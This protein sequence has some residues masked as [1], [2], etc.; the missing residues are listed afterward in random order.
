MKIISILTGS[1]LENTYIVYDESSKKAMVIDP[2]ADAWK[3][4]NKIDELNLK[5]EYIL[6]THGH[7]DHI[8]A[9]DAIKDKYGAKIAVHEADARMLTSAR[10]NLS[11]FIGEPFNAYGAD[12]LLKDGD[13][14]ETDGLRLKVLH[15]PGHSQGSVC[16]IAEDVIFSGDTLFAGSV[17][18]TD[19]PD[20]SPE[21]MRESLERLK[22]LKGDYVVYPGHDEQTTLAEEKLTNPYLGR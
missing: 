6:L 20:S 17:G 22:G 7:A 9:V 10:H 12:V 2:G 15:T 3:I 18:R 5:P 14:I 13:V 11:S 8:G 21:Q 19:F 4:E 1:L 16:F